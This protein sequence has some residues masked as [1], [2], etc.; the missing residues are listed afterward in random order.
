MRLF[1]VPTGEETVFQKRVYRQFLGI[2]TSFFLVIMRITCLDRFFRWQ[3]HTSRRNQIII[4]LFMGGLMLFMTT[5]ILCRSPG[6]ADETSAFNQELIESVNAHHQLQENPNPRV[7]R[8]AEL[9]DSLQVS[10]SRMQLDTA[11]RRRIDDFLIK[12]LLEENLM[13]KHN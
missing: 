11:Y 2:F 6:Q 9:L 13:G 5:S 7:R 3:Q 4:L 8:L 12:K 1:K 10:E